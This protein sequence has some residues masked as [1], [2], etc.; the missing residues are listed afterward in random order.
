[1]LLIISLSSR[2]EGPDNA[3]RAM[4]FS[5]PTYQIDGVTA[6]KSSI[7]CRRSHLTY[8]GQISRLGDESNSPCSTSPPLTGP[9]TCATDGGSDPGMAC[10]FPFRFNG[11]LYDTCTFEGNSPGETNPWCSTLTDSNDDHLGGQGR[12]GYCSSDCPVDGDTTSAPPVI[13]PQPP[14]PTTGQCG[15]FQ[16]SH[17]F[18][19][20]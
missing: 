18:F 4:Y 1:M 11:T 7:D 16:I 20:P 2:Y 6:G 8:M 19:S 17:K 9:S 5:S 10:V 15:R 12:W 13:P 3:I 14:S